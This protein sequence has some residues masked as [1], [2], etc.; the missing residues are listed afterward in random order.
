MKLQRKHAIRLLVLADQLAAVNGF[1]EKYFNMKDWINT[2]LVLEMGTTITSTE[3]LIACGATACAVGFAMLNPVLQKAGLEC[4]DEHPWFQGRSHW[5]A[6]EKFFGLPSSQLAHDRGPLTGHLFGQEHTR[7]P[8][9]EA[10]V[11]RRFV[12]RHAPATFKAHYARVL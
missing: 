11:L 5:A 9:E 10:G 1:G 3:E 6:V 12:R 7:T 2:P 4:R 8:A